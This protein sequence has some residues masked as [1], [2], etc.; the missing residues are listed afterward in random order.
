MWNNGNIYKL[1]FIIDVFISSNE[2]IIKLVYES[3]FSLPLQ[4]ILDWFEDVG[5]VG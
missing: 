3:L 4:E 2:K 1:M 5:A